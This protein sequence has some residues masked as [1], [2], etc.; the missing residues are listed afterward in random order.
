[1]TLSS[2]RAGMRN[3]GADRMTPLYRG[4][5]ILDLPR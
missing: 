5:A 2:E 1:M 4:M 3:P